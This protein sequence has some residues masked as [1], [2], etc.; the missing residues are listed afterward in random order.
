MVLSHPLRKVLLA[1]ANVLIPIA[2]L[3]FATGFFPYKPL[4][5]ELATF[6]DQDHLE[7]LRLLTEKS[8][9]G[10]LVAARP[11]RLFDKVIFMVVDA[12]RS[13]F[14]Y[15][16]HSGFEFVQSLIRDGGA[17]PFTAHAAAPTVTMPRVKALTT[18]SV[19]SFAD[20][21]LNLDESDT[22]SSLAH[23]DTWLAQIR[24][25]LYE[26]HSDEPGIGKIAF[27]GDD[28]W[29]KLFPDFFATH[30]GTSSFFVSDFT[31][32]D[33]NV[34]RHLPSALKSQKWDA[35]IMHYL[36]LDHIGHK[37]GPQGPNMLPKQREMDGIVEQIY[38]AM[39]TEPHLKDT[40][41]VLAG[42]HGMNSAGNH[43][44]S[45]EGETSTALVFASPKLQ[46]RSRVTKRKALSAPIQPK[47]GTEFDYYRK[48]QQPDLVPTLSAL[49]DVPIPKNSLGIIIPDLLDLYSDNVL[50][51][52]K[53]PYLQLLYRNSLQMLEIVKATY[54]ADEFKGLAGR[55]MKMEK[56]TFGWEGRMQLQC[57]W[58][59]A[60]RMIL[61]ASIDGRFTIKQQAQALQ[62]FLKEAQNTLSATASSYNVLRLISGIALAMTAS[63]ASFYLIRSLGMGPATIGF[64]LLT[65][66]YG[67][68]MFASSY[69]EEEQHIWYWAA[70]AWLAVLVVLRLRQTSMPLASGICGLLLL[71]LHRI[72]NRWNQ[73]GQKHA[74]A[75]DIAR[76]ILPRFTELLWLFAFNA[77]A[78]SAS[79]LTGTTLHGIFSRLL[80]F[81]LFAALVVSGLIFKF[82][83]TRADAPE[84]IG[85]GNKL[86]NYLTSFITGNDLVF[87]ARIVFGLLGLL[88]VSTLAG[89]SAQAHQGQTSRV[90]LVQRLRPLL[91]VLL[92]TQNRTTNLPLFLLYSAEY[93]LLR[94][95][96]LDARPPVEVI[97]GAKFISKLFPSNT[98]AVSHSILTSRGNAGKTANKIALT[99]L[100]LTYASFFQLGNSNAISSIDLSQA[101]N[102]ISS[103][104]VTAVGT[105]LFL[106]NWAGP[107]WWTTA[108]ISLLHEAQDQQRQTSHSPALSELSEEQTQT[109][110]ASISA[111]DQLDELIDDAL[112]PTVSGNKDKTLS[113][114]K[115]RKSRPSLDL[116]TPP[117]RPSPPR[118]ISSLFVEPSSRAGEE[119]E[120]DSAYQQYLTMTTFFT[121]ASLAATMLSCTILRTH[122]FIWTVFSP[123]YLYA[124]A[125]AI[126][127]HLV[128]NVVW[129][130]SL[131]AVG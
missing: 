36:G 28:T 121:A 35:M 13:D 8:N 53:N 40:I 31:E 37:T 20:L 45:A 17:Y 21:I 29:L 50:K 72:A 51:S 89:H 25:H 118:T 96:L 74:G 85:P 90:R 4:L 115:A 82:N 16:E 83:F 80:S 44:G 52:M 33:N 18:G 23:Q 71:V 108:G 79:S 42:D 101:Y 6:E 57:L 98:A 14:V 63:I 91:S 39:E 112:T 129:A 78:F 128:V 54:G 24:Q 34:T 19:P 7:E 95:I 84:L 109:K 75:P 10:A 107:I 113:K 2:C 106:S 59:R 9:N 76:N 30:D 119:V 124:V 103:Y 97:E 70:P 32:V 56:C 81:A 38:R 99:I 41:L 46:R 94:H 22:S 58:G 11:A 111:V 122:L 67:I 73:T 26:V 123:K 3:V 100:L 68:M 12:L 125:W 86:T 61:G 130:G 117:P 127:W 131:W 49:L 110:S 77:Y 1:L 15:G 62:D 27:Y 48:V 5:P 88:L 64:S 104:N 116:T 102:G 66:L 65:T 114:R 93:V 120:P 69:V 105:L 47:P 92:L 126:G 87:Q 43:G 60:Q 55:S